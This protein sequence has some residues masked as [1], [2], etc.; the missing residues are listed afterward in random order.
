[1]SNVF[2]KEVDHVEIVCEHECV[3]GDIIGVL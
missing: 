1:V 3:S 2:E